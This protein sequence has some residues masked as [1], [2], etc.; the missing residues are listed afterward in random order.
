MIERKR[1]LHGKYV[2]AGKYCKEV[3]YK[4][5]KEAVRLVNKIV[6]QAQEEYELSLLSKGSDVKVVHGYVRKLQTVPDRI[7][8]QR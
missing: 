1:S 4:E 2:A 3:V 5:Y 6:K 8:L 7:R